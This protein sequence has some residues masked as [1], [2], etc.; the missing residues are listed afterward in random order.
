[1]FVFSRIKKISQVGW[2]GLL[3]FETFAGVLQVQGQDTVV[4]RKLDSSFFKKEA[5]VFFV[6][7]DWGRK[8]SPEQMQV[9]S[10]MKRCA[11]WRKR[12]LKMCIM[13]IYP[14]LNGIRF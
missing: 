3:F 2:L 4:K 5:C 12:P 11:E 6:V 14:A 9:A 1:M 8:G 10:A 13:K 7:G